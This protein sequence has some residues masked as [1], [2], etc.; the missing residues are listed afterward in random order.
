MERLLKSPGRRHEERHQTRTSSQVMSRASFSPCLAT[1]LS[2]GNGTVRTEF[3]SAGK[4]VD[5]FDFSHQ[6][7]GEMPLRK[8][9][10][11]ELL[12][13]LNDRFA[14]F[15]ERV[16][17]LENQNRALEREIEDIKSKAKSSASLSKEYEPELKELRRQLQEIS[18][19]KRQIEIN[20]QNL[21]DEFNTLREK[22][23]QEA[24]GRSG[25]EES[26]TVLKKY[27]SDAYL[28][29]QEMNIKSK[30]LE[31]E[32][33]FL[34]KNHEIEVVEIMAQIQERQVTTE[35]SGLGG[36]DITAA[37]RDIRMQLEGHAVCDIRYADERFRTQVAKLTK[38]A[39]VNREA[40]IATKAEMTEYRRQLQSK[41]LEFD[42]VKGTRE[43]LER[44]IYDVE[45]RHNA[46]IHQYQDTIRE[47]EHELKNAKYDMGSH[48][49]EYQDLLN[50][51]MALDAEIYS[52]RKLL[53]GEESR[54]STLSDAHISAPYVYRQ[55]PVYTLPCVT[56]QGAV[57]RKAEPQYKFVEEIITETTREDVEISDMGSDD[58]G[59]EGKGEQPEKVKSEEEEACKIAQ[60]QTASETLESQESVAVDDKGSPKV[61]EDGGKP[62]EKGEKSSEKPVDVSIP[63]NEANA[64]TNPTQSQITTSKLTE[65]K[66]DKDSSKAADMESTSQEA[67]TR[68]PQA[69]IAGDE[70]M[71]HDIEQQKQ[72][73]AEEI[74]R[75]NIKQPKL[76][77]EEALRETVTKSKEKTNNL[78]PPPLK[79][80]KPSE[81][82]TEKILQKS[83][84]KKVTEETPHA[85]EAQNVAM[86]KP[87]KKDM[88]NSKMQF[89]E[90]S[91]RT[92]DPQPA[93]PKAEVGQMIASKRASEIEPHSS[94]ETSKAD[95]HDLQMIER[96]K[97]KVE[98]VQKDLEAKKRV[99]GVK[100]EVPLKA[101]EKERQSEEQAEKKV[102]SKPAA[103]TAPAEEEIGESVRSRED[104]KM[105]A[106]ASKP[107]AKEKEVEMSEGKQNS[108][109]DMTD[110]AKEDKEEGAKLKGAEKVLD[111]TPKEEEKKVAMVETRSEQ[112][113]H[114]HTD[115]D[116]G[117]KTVHKETLKLS[118]NQTEN[119]EKKEPPKAAEKE[120]KSS[121]DMDKKETKE[122][123]L[124]T[125]EETKEADIAETKGQEMHS[126]TSKDSLREQTAPKVSLEKE[127]RK[128]DT[129]NDKDLHEG[130]DTKT[131]KSDKTESGIEAEGPKVHSTKPEGP[132][133]DSASKDCKKLDQSLES[134]PKKS[135]EKG[136]DEDKARV[137]DK[138][139]DP[140]QNKDVPEV[141]ENGITS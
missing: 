24:R 26:I 11:K 83:E 123:Q 112:P 79:Y 52:Y 127:Q 1:S 91:A 81:K 29:K 73:G 7:S 97:D 126:K 53:E 130:R 43:A 19:Q 32:I 62:A 99:D 60:S 125:S 80:P 77:E 111:Q 25:A 122:S 140:K 4:S 102:D 100:K 13:G 129:K 22:Y 49:Q 6:F 84:D 58:A 101:K 36:S 20:Q 63:N 45:Q 56:R 50:V 31:D 51:K 33:N 69:D 94:A 21:E 105:Q 133:T 121:E 57:T 132:K 44:Q 18:V 3:G 87:T 14:R 55:S 65:E 39:E 90:A 93:F 78:I 40:L 72:E 70:K 28:A 17:Q 134:A 89:T 110:S 9:N 61:D 104:Q 96:A 137:P 59:G 116:N 30:A 15:I 113:S 88:E 138:Q 2:I 107:I 141:T 12:H 27:I 128:D 23:E 103:E 71:V 85:V 66:E 47:L 114:K 5:S 41:N 16:H 8:M 75:D 86:A 54:Y 109:K 67:E 115:D 76:T 117:V 131:E 139:G 120:T 34:K 46:G 108:A 82:A 48:V 98:E 135:S 37:L 106:D 118:E 35:V 74:C 64:D 136:Q 68:A 42:S 38:A 10:E 95:P 119:V 124:D 92:A